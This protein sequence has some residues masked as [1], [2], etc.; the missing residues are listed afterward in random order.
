MKLPQMLIFPYY[1]F[2]YRYLTKRKMVYYFS[3][4]FFL[5]FFLMYEDFC[6]RIS[7]KSKNRME[8]SSSSEDEMVQEKSEEDEFIHHPFK[9][10]DNSSIILNIRVC[11]HA[12]QQLILEDDRFCLFF[13]M[14]KPNIN[15]YSVKLWN[16][17]I[18]TSK[19]IIKCYAPLNGWYCLT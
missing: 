18:Q 15:V 11:G 7:S 4:I 1:M 5:L 8:S 10:K 3:F 9:V 14:L 6:K 2:I 17:I 13:W 16:S 19:V 12:I